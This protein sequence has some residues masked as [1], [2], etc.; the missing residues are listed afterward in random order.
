MPAGIEAL[1]RKPRTWLTHNGTNFDWHWL[2]SYGIP[3]P[4][5]HHDT[6]VGEQVLATT[7]RHDVRKDLGST[8]QRRLGYSTKQT[9][10][11]AGWSNAEL[12]E[13]QVE[14]AAGDVLALPQLFLTQLELAEQ[15]GLGE[16]MQ[17]EQAL[18]PIITQIGYNGVQLDQEAYENL[19]IEQYEKALEARGRIGTWFNANSPAQVQTYLASQGCNVPNTKATTLNLLADD[20]PVIRDVLI[21]RRA[22][23]R[24][25]MYEDKMLEEFADANLIVR[26]QY[27]QVAA[28]TTRFT[29]TDPNFQQVP[30]DMRGMFGSAD[31]AVKVVSADFS[32]IEVRFCAELSKDAELYL[33]IE[34]E[35]IHSNMA[36]TLFNKEVLEGDDR[37]RGKAGTFTL[38]FAGSIEGIKE[39]GAIVGIDIPDKVAEVMISRFF[40]R[41]RGVKKWH[42]GIKT[43]TRQRIV[44]IN[45][46]WGHKRIVTG[47]KKYLQLIANNMIQGSAAIGIKEALFEADRRGLTPYIGA[48]IHDEIMGTNVPI[49]YAKE[50]A[51]ELEDAMIVGMSRIL[52]SIPVKV[53][54]K[55][56]QHWGK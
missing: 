44:T 34:D 9:I 11:H 22:A 41:F 2:Q 27:W 19:L 24:S 48:L 42:D 3:R 47:N 16:A 30:R 15:R 6:L 28:E 37:F 53:E 8:L 45:L 40:N 54:T 51:H 18:T 25:S 14:Y 1:L 33:A 10:D 29:C 5:N 39:M 36:R 7:G 52:H 4:T 35:D 56:S 46:P 12:T 50:F 31:P 32:Q 20:F 23:K 26:S 55:I 21:L 17:K 49:T 13:K 38:I 43:A